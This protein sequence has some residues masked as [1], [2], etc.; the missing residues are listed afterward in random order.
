MFKD[1]SLEILNDMYYIFGIDIFKK[2]CEG[3]FQGKKNIKISLRSKR[4][5]VNL[6]LSPKDASAKLRFTYVKRPQQNFNG[7]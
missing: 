3:R 4:G 6:L 7:H 2:K 1:N 5:A